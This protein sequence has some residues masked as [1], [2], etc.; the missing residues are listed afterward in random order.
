MP[1]IVVVIMT[2]ISVAQSLTV[3]WE[4]AAKELIAD[5]R[6]DQRNFFVE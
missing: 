6:N 2:V 1:D 3:A 4:E 5:W